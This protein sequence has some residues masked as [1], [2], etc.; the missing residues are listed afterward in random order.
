MSFARCWLI[1]VFAIFVSGC[2]GPAPKT[3]VPT[4]QA[5]SDRK[6]AIFF[7]GTENDSSSRTNISKLH[8][9]VRAHP[10]ILTFYIEGVGV[11]RKPIGAATGWGIDVRVQKAYS[12]LAKNYRSGD[13]IYIFGFSRGAYSARILTA[14]LNY[15][16]LPVDQSVCPNEKTGNDSERQRCFDQISQIVYDSYKG[17]KDP[18]TRQDD[19]QTAMVAR[20]VRVNRPVAVT[21]LGV[22]DT[23]EALGA[24]DTWEAFRRKIGFPIDPDSG[25][26]NKKYGDQLCN[27]EQALHAVSI[28]D[29]RPHVFTP[30]LLTLPHLVESCTSTQGVKRGFENVNEVWFSGAHS[31]VGGGYSSCES[32]PECISNISLNWMI[33]EISRHKTPLLEV[34]TE[35]PILGELSHLNDP[36]ADDKLLYEEGH[37]DLKKLVGHT[38][39]SGKP[40][41]HCSVIQRIAQV[42]PKPS[43]FHWYMSGKHA[44][45]HTESKACFRPGAKGLSY[46]GSAQPQSACSDTGLQAEVPGCWFTVVQ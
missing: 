34:K 2:S 5:S 10:E 23:V 30:K 33:R 8:D 14:V 25:E 13:K 27:V 12:F 20:G 28:D 26:R 35:Q 19:I 24:V 37:R 22:W 18:K 45:S 1:V 39:N 11:G 32:K 40:Q 21:T 9:R 6:I 38:Y 7:D 43:E 3:Y 16:G 31:D 29:N 46:L 36:H 42:M 44:A 41:I 15:A 17:E 4:S